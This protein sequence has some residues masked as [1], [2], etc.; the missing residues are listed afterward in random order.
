MVHQTQASFA[1]TTDYEEIGS[2]KSE[3]RQKVCLLGSF[4]VGKTSLI[5]RFVE[6]RFDDRY[7]STIGAKIS[8]KKVDATHH[9]FDLYLWDLAG[10]EDF[11]HVTKSYLSGASGAIIV[12]D[13]TRHETIEGL[14]QYTQLLKELNPTIE[15]MFVGNKAD[16][17]DE[18]QI[19]NADIAE[20]ASLYEVPFILTS[21]K[22]GENVES[23]F[24]QFAI[25]LEG[26]I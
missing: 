3:I 10:G 9:T 19:T 17:E 4:S 6:D 21:A 18:R 8:R 11:Q 7:L 22:T 13:L 2:P 25:N 15:L 20:I 23:L 5:K 14:V 16:L 26:K 1:S 24:T 12:C